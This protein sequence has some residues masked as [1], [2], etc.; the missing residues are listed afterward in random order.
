MEDK[1][2]IKYKIVIADDHALVRGGLELVVKMAVPN[3]EIFQ[4]NNFDETINVLQSNF[5]IDLVLLDLM[6]PGMWNDSIKNIT[7]QFPDVP[8]VIVSVKE[9]FESIHNSISLGASGFI[10]KTSAPEVTISAIQ[11]VLSGGVYIPPH[12]L[13]PQSKTVE[14]NQHSNNFDSFNTL[15][16]RQRQVLDLIS[17]GRSNQAIA[18]ELNLTIPTI[19]MHVSAILKKLNVK[20]RTEAVSIYT[21]LEKVSDLIS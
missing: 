13:K 9:D 1:K 17:L 12:V 15:S 6:M 14:N 21:N 4:A 11:L 16:K 20:N 19:K 8:I 2:P 5:A 7:Q 10:P 18:D 3:A